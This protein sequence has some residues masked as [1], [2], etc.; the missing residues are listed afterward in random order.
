LRFFILDIEGM[1]TRAKSLVCVSLAEIFQLEYDLC[2]KIYIA[3]GGDGALTANVLLAVK[4]YVTISKL[5]SDA[6]G[7]PYDIFLF[8]NVSIAE[9][10]AMLLN[11]FELATERGLKSVSLAILAEHK[12][13]LG[14]LPKEFAFV[15]IASNDVEIFDAVINESDPLDTSK[16]LLKEIKAIRKRASLQM[17]IRLAECDKNANHAPCRAFVATALGRFQGHV[18]IARRALELPDAKSQPVEML[19]DFVRFFDNAQRY[20]VDF[21]YNTF[22]EEVKKSA[23]MAYCRANQLSSLV[24]AVVQNINRRKK[25]RKPIAA[26]WDHLGWIVV[27][28]VKNCSFNVHVDLLTAAADAFIYLQKKTTENLTTPLVN[29]IIDK[30]SHVIKADAFLDLQKKI[31]EDLTTPLVDNIINKKSQVEVI[32]EDTLEVFLTHLCFPDDCRNLSR[33]LGDTSVV[34]SEKSLSVAAIT[35]YKEMK[36]STM[37]LLLQHGARVCYDD[38]RLL[39][40][41]FTHPA[42]E[43]RMDNVTFEA[44][45]KYY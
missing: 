32:T 37:F 13:W 22:E 26:V 17:A 1:A 11:M 42:M 27:K 2:E 16:L 18:I 20:I 5:E 15:A 24:R 40:L 8:S 10:S 4:P 7:S 43:S 36:T 45:L 12:K 3:A 35:A 23:K 6:K 30:K 38:H 14:I 21:V 41:A 9:K 29:N 31:M 33:V 19:I 44:L 39:R 25:K 28:A 34:F